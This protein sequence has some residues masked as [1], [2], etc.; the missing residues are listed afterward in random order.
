M[1]SV[2]Q[3]IWELMKMNDFKNID[4][5]TK[6]SKSKTK[7]TQKTNNRR[8]YQLMLVFSCQTIFMSAI[9]FHIIRLEFILK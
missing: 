9:T 7:I 2:T 8:W 5:T 6:K 1:K 3:N 4:I